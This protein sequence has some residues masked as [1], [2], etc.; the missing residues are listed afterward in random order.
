ML[1]M[2]RHSN[3]SFDGLFE[4]RRLAIDLGPVVAGHINAMLWN[5]VIRRR[6]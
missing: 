5:G 6:G 1:P 3:S 2:L 4:Y